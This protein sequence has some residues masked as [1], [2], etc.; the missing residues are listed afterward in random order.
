MTTAPEVLCFPQ[1]AVARG[2]PYRI[3]FS[4]V[5]S[6]DKPGVTPATRSGHEPSTE[7]YAVH[8]ADPEVQA[9]GMAKYSRSALSMR[10]SM[11]EINEQKAEKFLNTFYFQYGHRSIADLAH[12]AFAIERLSILAATIVVDEP[13]W[14]GQERSTRYQDFQKSGYFVPDFADDA[15][16]R[17]V[18]RETI[19]L[20]FAE[21]RHFSDAM[22]VYLRDRT[23]RPPEMKQEAYERTLRARAFDLSRYLLPLASN[24]SLGQIVSAR[25]LESQVSRLLSDTHA[26]VRRLGELL[27]QAALEPSY[28]V[29]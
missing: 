5:S 19:D 16:A 1:A 23:P 7:V 8:G 4:A 3:S 17:A 24:T 26:E 15:A 9:Y 25:T 20:L 21:Y 29:N 14:D 18:Y 28:N 22:F 27:K 6:I 10:E 2:F 11:A 13:R 12:V